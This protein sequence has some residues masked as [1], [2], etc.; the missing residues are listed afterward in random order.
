MRKAKVYLFGKAA[1]ILKESDEG[2]SFQYLQSYLD[3]PDSLPVSLLF[4]LQKKTYKDK[5][6]FPFF[7]GLIP[8]GWLLEIAETNWKL[9]G[10]DRMGLLLACCRDTIGAASIVEIRDAEEGAAV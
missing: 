7:D 5:V 1:G 9:D 10:R 3:S 4:P 2:Y 6:L 8:E